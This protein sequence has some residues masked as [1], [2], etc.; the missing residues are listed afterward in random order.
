[1]Y[2]RRDDMSRKSVGF[3]VVNGVD[4][5]GFEEGEFVAVIE[6]CVVLDTLFGV[7]RVEQI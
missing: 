5:E 1:M 2:V 4:G 7:V 3:E 6:I